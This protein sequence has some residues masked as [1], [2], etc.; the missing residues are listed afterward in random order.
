M[1]VLAEVVVAVIGATGLTALIAALPLLE[2]EQQGATINNCLIL[3]LD[4]FDITLVAGLG[5]LLLRK[6]GGFFFWLF[7]W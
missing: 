7:G 3:L 4:L 5:F 6:R 1:R 2:V